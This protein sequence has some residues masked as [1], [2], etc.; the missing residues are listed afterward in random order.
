MRRFEIRDS[1]FEMGGFEN[2]YSFFAFRRS[3][4]GD[5]RLP[6]KLDYLVAGTQLLLD[7][8]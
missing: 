5:N 3:L 1:T 4:F 8:V 2:G 6:D 7:R